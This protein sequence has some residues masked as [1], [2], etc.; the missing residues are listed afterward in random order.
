MA[1]GIKKASKAAQYRAKVATLKEYGTAKGDFESNLSVIEQ[2]AGRFIERVKENIQKEDMVVTGAIEDITVKP[3]NDRVNIYAHPWLLYQDR[4]VNGAEVKKYNTPHS[5]TDKMPPV[6]VF[7]DW[8]REKN[9]QLRYEPSYGG[10]PSSFAH[11]D[12]E[13]KISKA[14]WGMAKKVYKE[15]FKPR[16]IYSKEIPELVDDLADELGD[17]AVSQVIQQ[18]D[19]KD[20]A[21]GVMIDL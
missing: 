7:K 12:N 14:A 8:I 10:S 11:L 5:Y 18:I 9:V 13:A 20:S 6:Y 15:G 21:K 17:F 2:V 19:V 3:E 4:G 16:H 1:Q